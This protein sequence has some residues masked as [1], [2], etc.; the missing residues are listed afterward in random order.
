MATIELREL[1]AHPT[2]CKKIFLPQKNY[3]TIFNNKLTPTLK[4][5]VTERDIRK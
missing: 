2:Q 1:L 5:K 4:K 3:K